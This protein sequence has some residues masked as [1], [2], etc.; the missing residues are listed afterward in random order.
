MKIYF[1]VTTDLNFDQRMIRICSSLS[2]AGH[3]VVLIGRSLPD[4]KPIL[5]QAFEQKRLNC[6]FTKGKLFYLE[7]NLRL[8]TYLLFAP[9]PDCICAIDL[10]SILPCYFT[11][12]LKKTKRVY[13][14]HELFCEMKEIATRPW[15]YRIWKRIE[16]FAVPRFRDG[17]TVNKPI[18][19]EFNRM[20]GVTYEV[21]RNIAV[22][23][24]TDTVQADE[25]FIL[26]QGAVN[27]GRC[28]E[29][30]IPAMKQVNCRLVI[31]G[32]GNFMKQAKALV[33]LHQLEKKV[34]FRGKI[35]PD[36]LREITAQA[37]LG[38]T[39][40]D[41]TGQSNYLSLANRFFDY[42]H[43]GIPQ[44]CVDFPIYREIIEKTPFARLIS[45]TSAENIA[46]EL[47]N[48]LENEVVYRK[49]REQCD[50]A[51]KIYNWQE[52]E[53]KLLRFYENL[54]NK[55]H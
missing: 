32:D 51:R 31:C 11:S 49:L 15:I 39:L 13:D 48:L 40:F 46:A 25:K 7:Y 53:K 52:E 30:L 47:N 10:D 41:R 14:A 2:G 19:D 55:Q 1:T 3:R 34:I 8:L 6:I 37:F 42:L 26:Y 36:K 29:T 45:D 23:R 27:E 24:Q 21:V 12:V 4:S 33:K 54:Q 5:P 50:I 43:A 38:I 18:A 28:F 16:Q 35:A 9:K 17:Y 22:L 44:L 20:Y